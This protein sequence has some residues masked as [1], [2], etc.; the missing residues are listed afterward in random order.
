VSADQDLAAIAANDGRFTPEGLAFVGEGLRHQVERVSQGDAARRRHLSA[1][2]LVDG[3]VD[4]AA[5]R[6]GALA[7]LVLAQWGLHSAADIGAVTFLLIEHGIFNRQDD[8]RPEDFTVLPALSGVLAARIRA[9][10]LAGPL[11]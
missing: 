3:V 7:D 1:A 8:D 4:L 2:E 5:R 11:A 6:Y 9:V 10:A